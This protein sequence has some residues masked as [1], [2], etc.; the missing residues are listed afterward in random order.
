MKKLNLLSLLIMLMTLISCSSDDEPQNLA[1]ETAGS[2]TGYTVA[3]SQYFSDMVSGEQ[4]VTLSSSGLNKINI[5]YTSD[6]GG[7]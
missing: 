6:R 2:Y 1:S 5:K 4:I 7:Q 3:S